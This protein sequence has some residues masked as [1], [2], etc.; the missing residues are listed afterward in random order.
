MKRKFWHWHWRL[1]LQCLWLAAG[2][3]RQHG[4]NYR[5]SSFC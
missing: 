4:I 2:Q 1:P 5:C 3:L